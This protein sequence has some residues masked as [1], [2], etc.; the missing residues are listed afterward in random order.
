MIL[1]G[2]IILFA[3]SALLRGREIG[4]IRQAFSTVGF[5][6]G[7]F[8]GALLQPETVKLAHSPGAQAI[9]TLTTTVGI[10]LLLMIVGEALGIRVK[11]QV[12]LNKLNHFDN[13]FGAVLSVTSLLLG[14]WLGAT[15]VS[16]LPGIN[17]QTA[18]QSSRIITAL[19][20]NLPSAPAVIAGLGRLVDP[21]GFP[22]VFI[23]SEPGPS[24]LLPLP[25]LGALG[26]AVNSDRS[27]VVK[28]EGQGCGGIVEGSGF[29]A[30]QGLIITNAHVIAGIKQPYVIDANGTHS[31]TPVWFD[32]SL[33]FAVL[34]V[35][36]LAGR[37]LVITNQFVPAGT[38]SAV[39]GYPGGGSFSAKPAVIQNQFTASGRD[40]YGRGATSR[41]IYEVQADIIPGNSGGPLIA[42]DGSVIGLV[43]AQSTS[44]DH[45]GY[46]LKN[47][48]ITG[49]FHQAIAQNQVRRTGTCAE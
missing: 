2:I 22:Q 13:L 11:R 40:I 25:D 45:V 9:V 47:T 26:A 7:L 41:D 23:G 36:N 15:I 35:P 8:I 43:F 28:V 42:T 18:F 6:G 44:Y 5:F 4:F 14:I 37:P 16:T 21:N 20:R 27:S 10:A 34:R 46:A 30:G 31:A 24:K 49:E 48:Q 29:V 39:L 33:D 38:A 12:L 32:P 3:I 19:D 1:D 17:A